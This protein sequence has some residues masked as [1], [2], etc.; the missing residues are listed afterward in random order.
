MSTGLLDLPGYLF[1]PV[2]GLLASLQVP[3]LLRVL[4]W[5]SLAGYAGMWI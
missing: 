3:A 4:L 2:D 1:G 5:G